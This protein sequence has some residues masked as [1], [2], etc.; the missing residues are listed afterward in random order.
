MLLFSVLK[1]GDPLRQITPSIPQCTA[2]ADDAQSAKVIAESIVSPQHHHFYLYANALAHEPA[3]VTGENICAQLNLTLRLLRTSARVLSIVLKED[4]TAVF[5]SDTNNPPEKKG[6]SDS[7]IFK[8]LESA[9]Q[10]EKPFET[11]Q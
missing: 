6:S 5:R 11:N 7:D 9:R 2:V 8:A 10:S 3:G 4:E 1:Y